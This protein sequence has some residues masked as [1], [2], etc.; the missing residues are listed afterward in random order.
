VF[1]GERSIDFARTHNGADG[2]PIAWTTRRADAGTGRLDLDDLKNRGANG[3]G[4]DPDAGGPPDLVAFAYAE[5]DCDREGPGLMLL[6]SSSRLIVTVNEQVVANDAALAGRTDTPDANVLRF[7]LARGRN[8]IL[9]QSRQGIG[10]WVFGV[11]VARSPMPAAPL[12]GP[13]TGRPRITADDLRRFAMA[14]EGDARRGEQIFF[15]PRGIGCARCHSA[16]GRGTASVGPDLTGLALKYDRAELIR[17]VLEP[18]SRIADG[19]QPVVV[20]THD[21]RVISGVVRGETSGEIELVDAQ[22]KATRIPLR[23]IAVRR[24]GGTSIM[25]APAAEA[26]SPA[27]FADLITFLAGLKQDPRPARPLPRPSGP[28]DAR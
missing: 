19:Y 15:D 5:V 6:G 27:D 20:A 23:D 24:A 2:R 9:V 12:A 4:S 22:A 10:P 11:Q 1:L 7:R 18:S 21:G 13:S 3:G 16:G 26:L 8:R 28:P 17:S 14:H 25:P